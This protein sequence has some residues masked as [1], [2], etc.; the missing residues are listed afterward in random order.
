MSDADLHRFLELLSPENRRWVEAQ[1][2]EMQLKLNEQYASALHSEVPTDPD[3][4]VEQHR[5]E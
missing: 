2:R 5:G 3:A 4:I 1:A